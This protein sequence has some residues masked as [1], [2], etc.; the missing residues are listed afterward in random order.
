MGCES[1][2]VPVETEQELDT[3]SVQTALEQLLAIPDEFYGNIGYYN[4]LATSELAVETVEFEQAVV[5]V[6]L[7]GSVMIGGVC[8]SP[9]MQAQLEKTVLQ[10]PGVEGVQF[11]INGIA[12][13]DVFS[14]QR[15]SG[16]APPVSEAVQ[17]LAASLTTQG[18]IIEPVR[19]EIEGMFA[20]PT[21]IVLLDGEE[22][23]LHEFASEDEAT[24]AAATI[25]DILA[26]TRW[27]AP[28]HFYH[29]GTLIVL[30]VGENATITS[31]LEAA[32]GPQINP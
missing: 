9:V 26:V 15:E 19:L 21:L 11:F 8:A 10:F 23:T 27:S 18:I 25:P 14:E 6:Q 30:Y 32:L 16:E 4:P 5:N 17:S 22:T 29:Q 24:A 13:Q 2:I 31:A 1:T 3:S 7:V 12:L 20:A 28:P